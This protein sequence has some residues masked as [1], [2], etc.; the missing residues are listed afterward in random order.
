MTLLDPAALPEEPGAD[1]ALRLARLYR[2]IGRA[3]KWFRLL[4]LAWITP[5]WRLL[6]GD[7]PRGQLPEIWRLAVVPMLAIAGF[8]ALWASLT[9]MV[10]T[11]LGAVPGPAQVW[12]QAVA[13]DASAKA[14][15]LKEQE[16]YAKQAD[17]N[18]A[19]VAAGKADEVKTPAY[20]GNPVTRDA[21]YDRFMLSQSVYQVDPW[22]ELTRQDQLAQW[23]PMADLSLE[24]AQ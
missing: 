17:K 8:L 15:R 4:G 1:R 11:S 10:Q 14:D 7:N 20:T 18:A 19:L 2:T 3:D 24:A 12:E 23:S 21:L 22:A 16:F 5:I 13:L 9:P 6:A